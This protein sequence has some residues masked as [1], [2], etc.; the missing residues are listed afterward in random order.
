MLKLRPYSHRARAFPLTLPLGKW[1]WDSFKVAFL[2]ATL[3]ALL[4]VNGAIEIL[5]IPFLSKRQLSRSV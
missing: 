5:C 2:V 1:V 4:G 3:M